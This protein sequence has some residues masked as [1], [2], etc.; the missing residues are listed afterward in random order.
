MIERKISKTK[1]L[2]GLVRDYLGVITIH[3]PGP[4]DLENKN[5]VEVI[6]AAAR[7]SQFLI[8]LAGIIKKG[9]YA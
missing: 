2:F 3:L 9:R 1:A 8:P 5:Q 7:N 4:V 6:M